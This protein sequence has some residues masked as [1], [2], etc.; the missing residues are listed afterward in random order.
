MKKTFNRKH[1]LVLLA[2]AL[3]AGLALYISTYWYQFMLIQ[4]DSMKPSYKNLSFAIVDKHSRDFGD[5]DVVAIRLEH[6]DTVIVKRIV[7]SP[8]ESVVISDGRLY[9]DGELSSHTFEVQ[10][11][12]YSGLAEE[13]INLSDSQ[14]FV[15]GDN[16]SESVDSRYTDIGLID[17]ADII[18]KICFPIR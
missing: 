7:A 16:Y 18:G 1:I 10:I 2:V 3:I 12:D 4:G 9:V 17:E 14:F 11:I 8:G 13:M 15:L 5:G 6:L